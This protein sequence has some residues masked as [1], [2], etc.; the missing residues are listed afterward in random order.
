MMDD[1]R[2]ADLR[3]RVA[4][5]EAR[6][7]AAVRQVA[8]MR[9]ESRLSLVGPYAFAIAALIMAGALYWRSPI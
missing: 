2:V 1:P 4:V 7:D 3:A 8:E 9:E 5:L 6:P